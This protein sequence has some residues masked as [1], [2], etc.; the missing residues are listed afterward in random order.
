MMAAAQILRMPKLGLTMESGVVSAWAI[1]EGERF[2]AGQTIVV[3]E[4]D[5]IASEVEAPAAGRLLRH[6]ARPGDLVDVG[7]VI[8]EFEADHGTGL[9][10]SASPMRAPE[11]P[12]GDVPGLSVPTRV[13]SERHGARIIATPLARR[14]AR[15]G[16]IALE[17]LTGS[18]PGGRIKAIDVEAARA[19]GADARRRDDAVDADALRIAATRMVVAKRDI[20]HFYLASEVEVSALEDLRGRLKQQGRGVTL[21][22]FLIAAIVQ[23]LAADKAAMRVWRSGGPARL[24]RID[25]GVAIETPAGLVAPVLKGLEG[26][27]LPSIAS[28]L[29]ALARRARGGM[30]EPGDQDGEPMMTLSNAG[31]HDVTWMTSIIPPGQSAIL[32]AGSVRA[33]FRPD[34]QGR[35]VLSREMGLVLSCDHRIFDGVSGL[36]LLN[37]IR[38]ALAR[39]A[40]LLTTSPM[41]G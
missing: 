12:A 29:D 1:A 7:A 26:A 30:L 10:A 34:A 19:R 27:D 32:G 11:P 37:R 33:T 31:M 23:A 35:P 40:E 4:T 6:V 2:E 13:A 8:A 15:Q 5:K 14:L 24:A 9:A 22:C 39:P 38:A 16:G 20:P 36:A 28:R 17:G 18:G 25:L 3:V 41:E 21:T